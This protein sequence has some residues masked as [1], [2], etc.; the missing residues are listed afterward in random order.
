MRQEG[1]DEGVLAVADA[2][3]WPHPMA[4]VIVGTEEG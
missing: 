2:S 1:S 3:K 4:A